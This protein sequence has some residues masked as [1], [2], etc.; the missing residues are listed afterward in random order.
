MNAFAE[1][2]D[3][4]TSWDGT[5]YGY[6]NSM[7]LRGDSVLNPSNRIARLAQ[8]GDNLEARF[9]FKAESESMRITARPIIALRDERNAFGGQTRREAYLSQYQV[10]VR[11]A[12]GWNVAAGRE[13]MNWGAA[14][15][16]SPSSPFYFD[17]GRS[18][19][20]RELVGMDALKLTWT[21]DMRSSFNLARIVRSGYGAPQ[22]DMW[23]DSWLAK[24]DLRGDEFA[25][26]AVAV[27]AP[28]LPAFYGAHGQT[29]LSDA[30]LLYGEAGSSAR[31]SALQSPANAA[32]P[33]VVQT[34][35]P[36]RTTA[37]VGATYTAENGKSLS[38]EYLHESHGYAAAE[39]SAYFV[40][41]AASPLIA[42]QA[43]GLAPRLLGRD[44]LHLVWQS[45]LMESD[46][47]WRLMYT[48]NT[49][50]GSNELGAYGEKTLTPHLSAFAM[51][52]W[53]SGNARQELSSLFT[54]SV[55][56]GLK[57]ALP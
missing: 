48:H 46:G 7:M 24:L 36:R 3:W 37:L 45:N 39:I 33:F 40:R 21:P 9:N 55:T 25:Y 32:Q 26:G 18:D 17:N 50:D 29:T 6:A 23:R 30:W 19:P 2:S 38:A 1:D 15:F 11:A 41:A 13:V 43:L 27:K 20:M 10:R 22:P 4:R 53:N 8:R 35:S 28:N 57:V 47:Y 16:R 54:Q 52:A 42:A 14:Q 5:L 44:Y 31:P 34:L 51:G 12:D 49:T 56:L